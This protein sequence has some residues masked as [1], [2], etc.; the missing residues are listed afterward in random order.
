MIPEICEG[1]FIPIEQGAGGLTFKRLKPEDN[2][3]PNTANVQSVYDRIRMVDA[4]GYPDGFIKYGN[5]KI[6]FSNA[7]LKDGEVTATAKIST[8]KSKD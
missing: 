3:I 7:S 5:L 4:D 2:Q 8:T 6:E 1:K